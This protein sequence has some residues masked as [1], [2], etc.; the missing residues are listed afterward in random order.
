MRIHGYNPVKISSNYPDP[1]RWY[2]DGS[3]NTENV[4]GLC[5][6]CSILWGAGAQVG[7]RRFQDK[8]RSLK[9]AKKGHKESPGELFLKVAVQFCDVKFAGPKMWVGCALQNRFIYP[10]EE[11]LFSKI[12]RRKTGKPQKP[13]RHVF[14]WT[15]DSCCWV[16]SLW[17]AINFMPPQKK[18]V[19]LFFV[20]G[21]MV[22]LG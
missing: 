6:S 13:L 21:V 18:R 3:K 8:W 7:L 5:S 19:F 11:Y 2:R 15:I 20:T 17:Y 12:L 14:S 16:F 22:G 9:H 4:R 10:Y 1:S